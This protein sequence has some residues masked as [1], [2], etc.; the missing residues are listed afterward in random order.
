MKRFVIRIAAL[1][2]LA[3]A[4][5][6]CSRSTSST[7]PSPDPSLE[8]IAGTLVERDTEQMALDGPLVLVIAIR[9]GRLE[10]GVIPGTMRG[11]AS[12]KERA[13]A[14]KAFQL[15]IGSYVVAL[16]S[17]APDGTF[18]VKDLRGGF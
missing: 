6:S 1:S 2:M 16:G 14:E 13:V 11:D 4:A 15:P 5:V 10:H 17:R 7:A 18:I 9:L 8:R 3:L 12:P